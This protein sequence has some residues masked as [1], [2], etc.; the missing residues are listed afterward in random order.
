ME[1]IV[2]R[3]LF[4]FGSVGAMVSLLVA[5][6]MAAQPA[7]ACDCIGPRFD[8][9]LVD[10]RLVNPSDLDEATVEDLEAA[11]QGAWPESGS[12]DYD[13]QVFEGTLENGDDVAVQ[14][15]VN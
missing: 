12:Y 8:M 3:G 15:V 14:I 13:R 10:V 1:N 11:E 5:G 2:K 9:Q 7:G 6:L 4:L